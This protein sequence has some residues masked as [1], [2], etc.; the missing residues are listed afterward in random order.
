MEDIKGLKLCL[1]ENYGG[2]GKFTF[3]VGNIDIGS[4]LLMIAGP[5]SIESEEQA[6]RT[7]EE[8]KKIGVNMLRGGAFKAR[9]SP[10]DFQGLG[11]EGLSIIEKLKK[12]T[13]LPV[14]TEV[15]D[16][17]DI[18]TVSKYA[19]ILQ[20][21]SR[22]MQNF[23][24]LKEAGKSNMPVLLKRGMSSTINE[25]L[26]CA[27]Y[28][29]TEGNPNVILCERGIRTFETFTRNTVDISAVPAIKN[30]SHLPVIVDPSHG[31]GRPELIEAVSMASVAAG[32]DGLM[33]EVHYKPEIAVSDAFQA[34]SPS[35]YEKIFKKAK[36]LYSTMITQDF[37]SD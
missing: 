7:A 9:T 4:D 26:N 34:I 35:A 8:L 24:L 5:C 33:I 20:I 36:K 10:Y 23:S 22:N 17:R 1:R 21:G 37:I 14:V 27:E 13:R 6:F 16:T 31:T 19:D 25:W 11:L 30:I 32:A 3:R 2:E 15:I 29:M 18:E 28:I 12:E